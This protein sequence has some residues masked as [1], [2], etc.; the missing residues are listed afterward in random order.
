MRTSPLFLSVVLII[1]ELGLA[2]AVYAHPFQVYFSKPVRSSLATEEVARGNADL[3]NVATEFIDGA[4]VSIDL[5]AY[6]ISH[7]DI[8][9]ALVR[10]RSRG[11]EVRVVTEYDNRGTGALVQIEAAGIPIIDDTFGD[12]DGDGAMHHKFIVRDFRGDSDPTNDHVWTGS[13][14][15][16]YGGANGNLENVVAVPSTALA[17][18]FT[19]EFNEMWGSDALTPAQ[20]TSRFGDRKRKDAPHVFDVDGVQVEVYMAPSDGATGEIVSE[21]D[22]SNRG[23]RFAIYSFTRD[24]ISGAMESR[25]SGVPGYFVQ[26]VFDSSGAIEY[27]EYWDMSGLPQGSDPWNPPADVYLSRNQPEDALLHHKYMLVDPGTPT[28]RVLTGSH[29]WSSA[30][31]YRNDENLVIIHSPEVVNLYEQ[32]F[33]ARY[34]E[35][36]GGA[37]SVYDV[38]YTGAADGASPFDGRRVRISGVVSA[39][40]DDGNYLYVADSVGGAWSGVT[41]Y[42]APAGVQRGDR[43]L[44]CGEVDEYFGLT[45]LKELSHLDVVASGQP[46]PVPLRCLTGDV[47]DER[48]EGVLVEIVDATVTEEDLGYGEWEVDDGSGPVRVDD[49]GTYG[50]R[51]QMGDRIP[52]LR[53][54]VHHSF[55]AFK[56]EPRDDADF[57]SVGVKS[58]PPGA[59]PPSGLA[60]LR[61]GFPN[62]CNPSISIPVS[63]HHPT[64]VRLSIHDLS[65]RRVAVLVDG[66]LAPGHHA[67]RWSGIGVS[68]APVASGVYVTTL[69]VA[70]EGVETPPRQTRRIVVL[71]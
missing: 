24:D 66:D 43:V 58:A 25:Y 29:N 61:A 67:F 63:V 16:S 34:V 7:Y 3:A 20:S 64:R 53:G 38:Q 60:T 41:L 8:A 9:D 28:A 71:R 59:A 47:A 11:V 6:N 33:G 13:Y 40:F 23:V 36:S 10:A 18:T 31:R 57:G 52:R 42:P 55:G 1:G 17:E 49:L 51:P 30:A 21:I 68:G 14:N 54:V 5:C 45:E 22:G 56:L 26:G 50:Y 35:A 32:E 12:N 19:E 2:L 48:H 69:E 65:G 39:R 70:R 15:F 44:V 37:F 62:P 46:E 4:N 27:S